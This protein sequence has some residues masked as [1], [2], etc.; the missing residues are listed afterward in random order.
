LGVLPFIWENGEENLCCLH[1]VKKGRKSSGNVCWRG[2]E[3]LPRRR[4]VR[5]IFGEHLVTAGNTVWTSGNRRLHCVS[6][7]LSGF[8]LCLA[9]HSLRSLGLL[10]MVT[11]WGKRTFIHFFSDMKGALGFI[12]VFLSFLCGECV[13]SLLQLQ[14]PAS[15]LL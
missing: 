5:Q 14:M 7:I 1:P 6:S 13:V 11:G 2:E 15:V 8:L 3:R 9:V 12:G 10:Y 4:A